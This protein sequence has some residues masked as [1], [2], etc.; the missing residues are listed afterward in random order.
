MNALASKS[1]AFYG[2]GNTR[3][4]NRHPRRAGAQP[5]KYQR[6]NPQK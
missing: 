2:T 6:F 5:E 4:I 3:R 1:K